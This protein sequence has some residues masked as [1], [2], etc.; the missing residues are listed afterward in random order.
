MECQAYA[1]EKAV[2]VEAGM[3]AAR[4][5][6]TAQAEMPEVGQIEKYDSS[7][8]TVADYCSQ[9]LICRRLHR[10]FPDDAIVAEEDASALR[11]PAASRMVDQICGFVAR[12][13]SKVTPDVLRMWIDLGS[14]SVANRYWV[15]DPIDGTRGFLR[16]QQFAVVIAL[17]ENGQ[18]QV[19]VLVCPVLPAHPRRPAGERGVVF[20]AVRGRGT[21]VMP[22]EGGQAV[23]LHSAGALF[24]DPLRFVESVEQDHCNREMQRSVARTATIET[25]PLKMD[26]QAKYGA[27]ARGEAVSYLRLPPKTD[28][29]RQEKTWD[30]A[31]G[32][33]IVEEAGGRVTDMFGRNLDFSSERLTHNQGIVASNNRDIHEAVVRALSKQ[34]VAA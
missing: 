11:H 6:L 23:P 14:S 13:G 34:M 27:V 16:R 4:L 10:E 26:S 31:A 28:P 25:P 12:F 9:A 22:F 2:A 8:V 5:C 3:E 21:E 18:V 7:P 15:V 29:Y 1:R 32:S 20:S 24:S 19:G 30:H 17:V 33:L